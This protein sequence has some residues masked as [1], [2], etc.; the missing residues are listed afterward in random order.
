MGDRAKGVPMIVM[1]GTGCQV[2]STR[3]MIGDRSPENP[4][5]YRRC[6]RNCTYLLA[7]MM[8]RVNGDSPA[9]VVIPATSIN[10]M[11]VSELLEVVDDDTFCGGN[12]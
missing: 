9:L 3:A 6:Y 4:H 10:G 7:R 11:V 1:M 5:P 12:A 2:G 8:G